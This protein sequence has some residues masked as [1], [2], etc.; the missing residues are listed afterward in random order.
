MVALPSTPQLS[1]AVFYGKRD[2]D[3][4]SLLPVG[5]SSSSSA[6]AHSKWAAGAASSGG[7]KV[8]AFVAAAVL[9]CITLA[10]F[11]MASPSPLESWA[12]PNGTYSVMSDLDGRT[13]AVAEVSSDATTALSDTLELMARIH[14]LE[15]LTA[16]SAAPTASRNCS[17]RIA[18]HLTET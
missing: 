11:N 14:K 7:R 4:E 10:A 12:R 13:P 8:V 15:I 1:T 3:E 16:D 9:L 17:F 2:K 18:L 5:A 6:S